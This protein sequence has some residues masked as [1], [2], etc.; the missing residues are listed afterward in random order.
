MRK[1]R[2]EKIATYSKTTFRN[3]CKINENYL[4]M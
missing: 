4:T 3:N 1:K 2:S